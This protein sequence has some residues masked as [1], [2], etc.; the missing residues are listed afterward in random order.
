[1]PTMPLWAYVILVGIVGG[2]AMSIYP[3]LLAHAGDYVKPRQMVP[4]CA[5]LMLA[6]AMGMAVGPITGAFAMDVLGPG[7]LFI[8]TIFF[9]LVFVVFALYRMSKRHSRPIDER[10]AF[11]NLPASST[12]IS[13]LDPRSRVLSKSKKVK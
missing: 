11:V 10:P 5:T 12:A 7:G 3:I 6:F 9:S 2:F 8:H 13:Q 4:L 1:M